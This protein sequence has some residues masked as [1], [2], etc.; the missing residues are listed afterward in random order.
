[1]DDRYTIE[2]GDD[3]VEIT[4][5]LTIE[6]A[7]DYINFFDKKGYKSL[8]GGFDSGTTICMSR[9]SVEQQIQEERKKEAESDEKFYESL[10]KQCCET[11]K[12]YEIKILSLE[13]LI[14]DLMTESKTKHAQK[15][16]EYQE[17]KK[18]NQILA[19]RNNPEVQNI[20]DNLN[21]GPI[22]I[23]MTEEELKKRDEE[24]SI[25]KEYLPKAPV[26]NEDNQ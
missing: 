8:T 1:M 12:E 15:E 14:K 18:Y 2:V 7:F 23:V 6:E 25:V 19:M 17:L 13:K 11:K 21:F 26:P 24:L 5:D 3:F 22:S 10:Y 4:G 16:R 20:I 9:K